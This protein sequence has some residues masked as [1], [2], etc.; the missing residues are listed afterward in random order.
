M[1]GYGASLFSYSSLN[2]LIRGIGFA[3][4]TVWLHSINW[5]SIFGSL[6]SIMYVCT[7]VNYV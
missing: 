4:D 7:E 6:E 2:D 3:E 5:V 1:V